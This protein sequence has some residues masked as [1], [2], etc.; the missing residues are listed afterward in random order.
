VPVLCKEFRKKRQLKE[1]RRE[2]S[3]LTTLSTMAIT[4][5]PIMSR[6]MYNPSQLA[7]QML[8]LVK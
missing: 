8:Q 6:W 4:K 1:R 3:T 5:A 7:M 2:R